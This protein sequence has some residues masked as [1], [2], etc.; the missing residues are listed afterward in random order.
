MTLIYEIFISALLV[1][2]GLFGLIGS[3][4]LWKLRD[5]LQRLHSPTKASTLG[6]GAVLVASVLDM[7]IFQG[8]TTWQELLIVVF[9]FLTAP[10]SALFLA[11][12]HLHLTVQRRD[13]PP[14]GTGSD[15]A[16]YQESTN[17]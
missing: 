15:W 14:T 16:T 11:K 13:L 12:V 3:F 6:V 10:V 8:Q 4:G 1:I 7:W 17:R 2:G 9:I 5:P